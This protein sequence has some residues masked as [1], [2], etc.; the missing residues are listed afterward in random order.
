MR[1]ERYETALA[2]EWDDFNLGSKNGIFLF[3]R[4]YLEYHNDR[5]VDH[6]LVIF[7]EEK[8]LALFP[9]NEIEFEIHSHAGL[10]FGSL[11]MGFDLKAFEVL[12]IFSQIKEY[13]SDLGFKKIV[14]KAIPSIFQKYASDE[15]I[16]ALFRNGAQ[17]FRRDISSVIDLKNKIRFSESKRQSIAKCIQDNII[18]SENIDFKEY[19]SLLTEVLSKFDVKPV[20]SLQEIKEL[21]SLFSKEIRLFEARRGD[22]LLAGIVIYDYGKVV[23]TQ[24]M[25]NSQEGRK[26]GA[27]DF[28]NHCLINQIFQDREYYSFGISTESQG[29]VLNEGLIQQKE[30]MGGRGI[31]IDFYSIQ[32]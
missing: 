8:I 6:S 9:A 29:K 25:A 11:I 3:N 4:D 5:F 22:E 14:Y 10:T 1:I 27:L 28:I 17:L 31:A 2:S 19:W 18:F 23:H 15:D 12:E 30:M 26:I 32:L 20:H 16:Y 21:K 7:K 24:Y 13:Y